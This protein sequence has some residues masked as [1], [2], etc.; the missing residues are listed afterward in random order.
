MISLENLKQ[1]SELQQKDVLENLI[2]IASTN[3]IL[4][5]LG[6]S[7]MPDYKNSIELP[8]VGQIFVAPEDGF[9]SV[10]ALQYRDR[11]YYSMVI[12]DILNEKDEIILTFGNR[13]YSDKESY[14]LS[15]IFL[16]IP[17]GTRLRIRATQIQNMKLPDISSEHYG[18][19]A[20]SHKKFFP[21]LKD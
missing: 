1:L 19:V 8:D 2:P 15:N 9:V 11:V 21:L 10:Q 17:K 13:C 5:V 3:N 18:F 20:S 4:G 7:C 16:P 14:N 12:I 6:M